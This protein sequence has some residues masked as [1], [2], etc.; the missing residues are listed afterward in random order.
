MGRREEGLSET[1]RPD[2]IIIGG[3]ATVGLTMVTRN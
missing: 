2:F 1:A 3:K